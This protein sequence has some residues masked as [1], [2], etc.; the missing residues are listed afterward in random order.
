MK[1]EIFST[2]KWHL[3]VLAFI[4]LS[5]FAIRFIHYDDWMY[6]K[7]DQARDASI[8]SEAVEFGPGNL[9]LLGPKAGGTGLHLGPGYYYVVYIFASVVD[10][11]Q[12]WAYAY[13]NL[14][15]LSFSVLLLYYFLT[16]YFNKQ[17]SL[18]VT[19]VYASSYLIAQYA[20]F[21]WNPNSVPFW[22]LLFMLS[23]Y[24]CVT[25]QEKKVAGLWLLV[26]SLSY[27]IVSQLHFIS[28]IGFPAVAIVFW[29]FHRPK[30]INWKYWA[31][32]VVILLVL[33]CPVIISEYYTQGNNTEHFIHAIFNR[34]KE[35]KGG[36][37]RQTVK[38][39]EM[40]GKYY[41]LIITSFNDKELP[42]ALQIG[43]CFVLCGIT[44]LFILW[45]GF[46]SNQKHH[47]F[48]LLV[49]VWFAVYSV[50]FFTLAFDINRPRYW[51]SVFAVPYVILAIIFKFIW[52]QKKFSQGKIFVASLSVLLIIFNLTAIFNWYA[53]LSAQKER[54]LFGRKWTSTSLKQAD[55]ITV[56][57]MNQ[58][59]DFM[60]KRSEKNG[61]KAC[62][63]AEA[64]YASAYKYLFTKHFPDFPQ[65][66]ISDDIDKNSAGCTIFVIDE[67]DKSQQ[68][69]KKRFP[70]DLKV[71]LTEEPAIFGRI[72]VWTVDNYQKQE[73]AKKNN[74]KDVS[75][76][77]ENIATESAEDD[78]PVSAEKLHWRDVFKKTE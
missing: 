26:A 21:G 52:E 47:P 64:V 54:Q 37:I 3:W 62:H 24:K 50:L 48:L 45:K 10:S 75:S 9:P 74:I 49:A 30:K 73:V 76:P 65:D 56:E 63:N 13:S 33:Y 51:F 57:S 28:L 6:F 31:G 18:L 55:L 1:K 8:V 34:P 58:A 59:V 41:N 11:A 25:S 4:F 27:G 32:A 29:L 69:T 42:Y 5:S 53:S 60:H 67:E 43:V 78:E 16:Q 39:S 20:R 15:F 38:L 19:A 68:N 77:D 71:A 44:G 61:T 17:I 12:P 70:E 22:G 36:V 72:K 23:V 14:I 7:S 2:N 40:T 35:G 46:G 66:R